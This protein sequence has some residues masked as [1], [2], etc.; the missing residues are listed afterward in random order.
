MD[1]NKDAYG[2]EIMAFL[3]K[4]ESYEIVERDD[5]FIGTSSGATAYF[6]EFKYWPKIEKKAIRL[7]K[8]K[9]LDIGAGAGRVSLFLQKKGFNVTAIDNS[10]L[11]VQ[12]CKKRGVKFAKIL[13]IEDIGTL[14]PKTFDTIIMFGNNFGLFGSF[15]KA[16]I[17]LKKLHRITSQDA[18]ML[19]E[20]NN[21]Y[22]TTDPAHLEYHKFNKKRGRMAGQLRIRIRFRTYIGDWF[23][24]LIVSKEEMEDILKGTGW[25]VKK[26]IDSGKPMYIA[27]IE[28]I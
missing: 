22:N 21:V 13:P 10:P 18:L 1:T 6:A 3:L 24:Y 17:L 28:K 19:A 23:D 7:V 8:G 12:V 14:K 4:K 20:S 25:K 26:Y 16:K 27:V 15:K 2:Q 11:A 9:I 5:N